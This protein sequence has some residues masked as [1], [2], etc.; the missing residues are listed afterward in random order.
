MSRLSLLNSLW[1]A[2]ATAAASVAVQKSGATAVVDRA[3]VSV[4][5]LWCATLLG[6]VIC[7]RRPVAQ[8]LAIPSRSLAQ[9]MAESVIFAFPQYSPATLAKPLIDTELAAI[10]RALRFEWRAVFFWVPISSS[11]IY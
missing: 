3:L 7:V 6:M 5:L 4:S 10:D 2:C 1:I 11:P 8:T 9:L